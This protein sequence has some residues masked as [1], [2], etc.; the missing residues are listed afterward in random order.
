MVRNRP[1]ALL[2]LGLAGCDDTFDLTPVDE[3]PH[4]GQVRV[5]GTGELDDDGLDDNEDPCVAISQDALGSSVAWST[6][7]R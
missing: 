4:Y 3:I 6:E 1:P 2:I 7:A 5:F